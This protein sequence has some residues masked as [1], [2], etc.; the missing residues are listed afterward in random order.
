MIFE[1]FVQDCNKPKPTEMGEGYSEIIPG[2]VIKPNL[3]SSVLDGWHSQ[4]PKAFVKI[5]LGDGG[6]PHVKK[7]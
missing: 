6:H 3:G 1:N 5:H 2:W 7:P 4:Y